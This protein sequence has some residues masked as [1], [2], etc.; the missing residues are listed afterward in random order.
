MSTKKVVYSGS[1]GNPHN[2]KVKPDDTRRKFAQ[3]SK[4]KK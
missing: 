2:A 1:I 3:K 4:G